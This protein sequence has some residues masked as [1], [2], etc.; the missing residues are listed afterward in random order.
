MLQCFSQTAYVSF[1]PELK[2][3]LK[4]SLIQHEW[5]ATGVTALAIQRLDSA[6]IGRG[7]V[8]YAMYDY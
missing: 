6:V 3:L 7:T 1:S 8:A 5:G 4:R 2:C